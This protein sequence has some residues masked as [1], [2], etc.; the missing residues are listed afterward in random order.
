MKLLLT[1]GTKHRNYQT[2]AF[3]FYSRNNIPKPPFTKHPKIS[4]PP[5]HPNNRT[6][7][8]IAIIFSQYTK[9]SFRRYFHTS[10]YSKPH[11]FVIRITVH[12]NRILAHFSFY[13][14]LA[15][16]PFPLYIIAADFRHNGVF[17]SNISKKNV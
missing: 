7:D 8:N 4:P 2:P 6:A 3:F 11:C 10:S 17:T 12:S 9:E 13:A 14:R 5:K 15:S 16:Q 1:N